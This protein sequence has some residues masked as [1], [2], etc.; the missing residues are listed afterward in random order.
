MVRF[1]RS[2]TSQFAF[3]YITIFPLKHVQFKVFFSQSI[4]N[5]TAHSENSL[6]QPSKKCKTRVIWL[7]TS[8]SFWGELNGSKIWHFSDSATSRFNIVIMP[9]VDPGTYPTYTYNLGI[10]TALSYIK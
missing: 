3:R 6:Q 2:A 7:H 8:Q 1:T 4:S 5:A 10:G 9:I